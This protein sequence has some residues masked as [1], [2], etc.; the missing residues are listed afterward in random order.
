[1]GEVPDVAILDLLASPN[2][3]ATENALVA[4]NENKGIRIRV[5]RVLV[6]GPGQIRPRNS[7]F[8]SQVLQLTIAVG[9]AGHAIIR[10]IGEKHVE[11]EST[12]FVSFLALRVDDHSLVNRSGA[13]GLE[14]ARFF[15]GDDTQATGSDVRKIAV[16]AQSRNPNSGVLRGFQD[17]AAIGCANGFTVDD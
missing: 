9:L 5:D 13:R 17:G 6:T 14:P 4:I 7:I 16:V 1:V 12:G 2:A 3:P 8:V 15:Y 10:V 11:D